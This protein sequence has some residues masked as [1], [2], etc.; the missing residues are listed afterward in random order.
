M[1]Q[2]Y[3][4]SFAVVFTTGDSGY[5]FSDK[6]EPGD[7]LEVK[8]CCA[9]SSSRDAND[10]VVIGIRNG[11]QDV[12]LT[13]KAP[14]AA[15]W[16][17]ETQTPFLLGESDQAFAYFQDADNGCTLEIHINGILTP[18]KEWEKGAE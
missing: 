9:Y 13:A 6:M 11:G 17:V 1:R 7:V 15:E 2:I 4:R 18:L 16:G 14:L 8:S 10:D 5:V 12:I 3:N